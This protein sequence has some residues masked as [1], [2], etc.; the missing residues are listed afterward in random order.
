M[1]RN[2]QLATVINLACLTEDRSDD[3]QRALI[4]CA[5]DCDREH[6][7][8]TT[9]NRERR[10]P[11]FRLQNLVELADTTRDIQDSQKKI[12]PPKRWAETWKRWRE[13]L[14]YG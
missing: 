10:K 14:S 7:K 12:P 4:A 5:W 3:E 1:T 11:G 9:N 13:E 8:N 2:Q 6:N